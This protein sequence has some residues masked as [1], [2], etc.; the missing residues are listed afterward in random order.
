MIEHSQ[1][2]TSELA[3]SRRSPFLSISASR[4]HAKHVVDEIAKCCSVQILLAVAS[5]S[6]HGAGM[7]LCAKDS[8]RYI[9]CMARNEERRIHTRITKQKTIPSLAVHTRTCPLRDWLRNRS[10]Q[11]LSMK[12][13][14]LRARR[15]ASATSAR[16]T[17]QS[18]AGSAPRTK[19]SAANSQLRFSATLP[20]SATEDVCG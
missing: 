8:T 12:D 2:S 17:E 7:A 18:G 6:G 5:L 20:N 1:T 16:C 9:P 3:P 10:F 14:S 4:M 11:N 15:P 13:C 19:F